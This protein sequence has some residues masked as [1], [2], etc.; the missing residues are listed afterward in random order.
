MSKRLY[1]GQFL[2]K[3]GLRIG[4]VTYEGHYS[5]SRGQCFDPVGIY[6]AWS[7][8]LESVKRINVE[9]IWQH[10][11]PPGFPFALR[12]G[13]HCLFIV[14]VCA[15]WPVEV[16]QDQFPWAVWQCKIRYSRP[17]SP[18][19]YQ[20]RAQNHCW[21]WSNNGTWI[22][23]HRESL[24]GQ[25]QFI[26]SG[27]ARRCFSKASLVSSPELYLVPAGLKAGVLNQSLL[28]LALML[29]STAAVLLIRLCF[30][31]TVQWAELH[32]SEQTERIN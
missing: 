28:L 24:S 29:S 2:P 26:S 22:A 11:F 16:W 3:K 14:L 18:W 20:R 6:G 12:W 25:Q 15:I 21:E 8:W 32:S 5:N 23:E 9:N 10:L 7:E 27:R 31:C 17:S 30:S 13:M 19:S 4:C 1:L